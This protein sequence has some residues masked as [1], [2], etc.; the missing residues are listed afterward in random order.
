[1]KISRCGF[2]SHQDKVTINLLSMVAEDYSDRQSSSEKIYRVVRRRLLGCSSPSHILP[3]I[4]VL[5]SILKNAKGSFVPLV[6]DDAKDWLGTVHQ[7]LDG[8]QRQKLQKVWKTW[9]D[10]NIFNVDNWKTMGKCFSDS[11]IGLSTSFPP[12][13][14]ISRTVCLHEEG[15]LLKASH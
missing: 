10:C 13:A 7:R 9:N 1:M 12:V 8:A 15:R 4:Y 3:V 14:G 11:G 6:E 2:N 5:D